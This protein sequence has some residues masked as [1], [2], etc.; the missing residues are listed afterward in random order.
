MNFLQ[1]SCTLCKCVVPECKQSA[2]LGSVNLRNRNPRYLYALLTS[3]KCRLASID[4]FIAKLWDIHEKVKREGYVQV[5]NKASDM[6]KDSCMTSM[7]SI[8]SADT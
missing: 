5:S 4:D 2:I 6:I 1:V 3:C 8:L 7:L